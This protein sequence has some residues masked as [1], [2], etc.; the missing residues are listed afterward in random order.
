MTRSIGSKLYCSYS[1]RDNSS[2]ENVRLEVAALLQEW[3]V[4]SMD[5]MLL[6]E[7]AENTML[8]SMLKLHSNK[9]GK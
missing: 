8:T 3:L 7:Q 2:P 4:G 5:R 9:Y 6:A 1:A